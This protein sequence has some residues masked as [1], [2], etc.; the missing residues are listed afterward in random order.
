VAFHLIHANGQCLVAST[1]PLIRAGD[2]EPLMNAIA[3]LDAAAAFSR[4]RQSECDRARADAASQGYAAGVE[5]GRAAFAEAIAVLAAAVEADARARLE[6]VAD[7]ALA[8][9]RQI[10]GGL[11]DEERMVAIARRA[12]QALGARGPLVVEVSA[13]M[14]GPVE[15][16]FADRP[17]GVEILVR[18]LDVLADDQCRLT[19]PDGRI[20]ADVPVQLRALAERWETAGRRDAVDAP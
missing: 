2:R 1:S 12:A 3:L 18:G 15:R 11:A 4:D 13:A 9:L 6:T 8:A 19:G 14:A 5:Q 17:L 16:A 10:I 20:I 7:L